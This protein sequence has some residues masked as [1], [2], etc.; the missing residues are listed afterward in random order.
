MLL[1]KQ[2]FSSRNPRRFE[3]VQRRGPVKGAEVLPRS[4]QTLD[5]EHRWNNAGFEEA[6]VEW[7][8]KWRRKTSSAKNTELEKQLGLWESR[9]PAYVAGLR[10]EAE[11]SAL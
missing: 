10:R 1:Q 2:F 11:K 3:G 5:G 4:S 8:K 9:N 6:R 7:G